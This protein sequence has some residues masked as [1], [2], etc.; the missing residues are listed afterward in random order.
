MEIFL[1][2]MYF[3]R[4]GKNQRMLKESPVESGGTSFNEDLKLVG[5]LLDGNPEAIFEDTK[6]GKSFFCNSWPRNWWS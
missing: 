1:S 2:E 3:L 6:T 4:R 5:I